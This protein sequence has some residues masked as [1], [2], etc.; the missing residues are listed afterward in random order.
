MRTSLSIAS[1][2]VLSLAACGSGEKGG[3]SILGGGSGM[4][5]AGE[6]EMTIETVNVSA[7]NL[8]P[9]A[10]A[11]MKQ[12]PVTTRTCMSEEEARGPKPETLTSNAGGSNCKTEGFSWAGGKIKGT[13]TCTPATGGKM[14]MTMDG[15]YD[16]TSMTVNMKN[17]TEAQGM[18]MTMDIKMTGKRVGDCPAGKENT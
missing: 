8:P 11:Q 16:R 6:W 2:M 15:E 5:Q 10:L 1:V 9:G 14:T 12:A 3:D 7:P 18:A 17:A 4:M 13:T